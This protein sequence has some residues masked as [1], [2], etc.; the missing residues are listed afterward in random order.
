MSEEIYSFFK[1]CKNNEIKERL[2]EHIKLALEIVKDIESSKIGRYTYKILP[3][4]RNL[5]EI[6]KLT[7][8]FHDIGKIFYQDNKRIINDCEVLS[9]KGHEFLSTW[10]F[11]EI[12]FYSNKLICESYYGLDV[13]FPI[14]FAI[15]FHH[16]AMNITTRFNT[17]NE[18]DDINKIKERV[19]IV[20][21]EIGQF[22]DDDLKSKLK[23]ILIKDILNSLHSNY[24]MELKN[25]LA[26]VWREWIKAD[27]VSSEHKKLSLI[28]LS[29]LIAADVLAAKKV[30]GNDTT[31]YSTTLDEFRELYLCL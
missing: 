6:V 4:L 16:H 17:P 27:K 29:I 15:L 23:D 20:L 22:L 1:K 8:V 2:S 31:I 21:N 24:K 3:K 11:N 14:K 10:I 25:L 28:L 12:S 30:R 5:H 9:F 7:I 26:N 18:L 19:P 13:V